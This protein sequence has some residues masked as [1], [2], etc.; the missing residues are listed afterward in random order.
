MA[1]VTITICQ[2]DGSAGHVDMTY[3]DVALTVTTLSWAN[4]ASAPTTVFVYAADG[5][6]QRSAV[7]PVGGSGS[8]SPPNN[9]RLT[10]QAG[11]AGFNGWHLEMQGPAT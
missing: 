9:R 7:I 3:D 2:W 6:L 10:L 11:A 5:T 1:P 4:D 8:Y